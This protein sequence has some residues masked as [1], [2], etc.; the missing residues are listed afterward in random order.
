LLRL[1]FIGEELFFLLT[2][3]FT[4]LIKAVDTFLHILEDDALKVD[5]NLCFIFDSAFYHKLV[6]G[7]SNIFNF[8]AALEHVPMERRGR[9]LSVAYL[10]FPI[11]LPHGH[12]ALVLVCVKKKL[13]VYMDSNYAANSVSCSSSSS[14]AA[15]HS[16]GLYSCMPLANVYRFLLVLPDALGDEDQSL[17]DGGWTAALQITCLQQGEEC[18]GG[19][20]MCLFS[21]LFL[22]RLP[23]HAGKLDALLR[24]GDVI[25]GFVGQYRRKIA[26]CVLAG[27]VV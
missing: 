2:S 22:K 16:G 27:C 9:L 20:L 4:L 13:I 11:E 21:H 26:A 19:V 3:S 12:W 10:L 15:K 8:E 1:L 17:M 7:K 5:E 6:T 23:T 18:D 25:G 24:G 14:R